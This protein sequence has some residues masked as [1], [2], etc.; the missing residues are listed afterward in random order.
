MRGTVTAR[1]T[2]SPNPD[3]YRRE[4]RKRFG[5]SRFCIRMDGSIMIRTEQGWICFGQMGQ[6]DTESRLFGSPKGEHQ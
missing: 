6:D 3:A 4:L 5:K 2:I 1:S